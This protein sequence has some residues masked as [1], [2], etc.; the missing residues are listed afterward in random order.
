VQ[1]ADTEPP[2]VDVTGFEPG[3]IVRN[4]Q[5]PKRRPDEI[6]TSVTGTV[7]YTSEN[8]LCVTNQDD[9]YLV[10]PASP[11][12]KRQVRLDIAPA[13]AEEAAA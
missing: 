9:M 13:A 1:P 4:F 10:Y 5:S 12:G 8:L 7:T 6:I 2:V 3:A 11:A